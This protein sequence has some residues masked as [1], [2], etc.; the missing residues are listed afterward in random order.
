VEI[1]GVYRLDYSDGD[2]LFRIDIA[3]RVVPSLG[4][5][6]DSIRSEPFGRER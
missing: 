1:P 2:G 3:H 5:K 4:A 6:L